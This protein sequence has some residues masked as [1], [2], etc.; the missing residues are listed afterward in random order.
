MSKAAIVVS[1]SVY[2]PSAWWR[3]KPRVRAPALVL[4]D[5]ETYRELWE[6]VALFADPGDPAASPK[7]STADGG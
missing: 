1:P 4:A 7:P 3:W 6:G 2:E 5:I